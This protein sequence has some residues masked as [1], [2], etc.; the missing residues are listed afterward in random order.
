MYGSS[1]IMYGSVSAPSSSPESKISNV[2]PATYESC[3]SSG[4]S[5][6]ARAD[7]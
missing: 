2:E 7:A 1:S 5:P 4:N 3:D 6:A